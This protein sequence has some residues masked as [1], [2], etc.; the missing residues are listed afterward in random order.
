MYDVF[1]SYRRSDQALARDLVLALRGRGVR[2][3]WD[4]DIEGGEDWREAIVDNLTRS[5]TLV[6]LFSE[7]CNA[8]KQLKKEL[9]I[10]DSLDKDV[11][12]ILIEDT[13]PRGHYLYELATRNWL[14]AFPDPRS[15]VNSLADRLARELEQVPPEHGLAEEVAASRPPEPATPSPAPAQAVPPLTPGEL[16]SDP[17]LAERVAVKARRRARDRRDLLALKWYEMLI[18]LA[19]GALTAFGTLDQ[20]DDPALAAWDFLLG[21]VMSLM[22]IAVFVL[23]FRYYFRRRRV[24]RA[25][26]AYALSNLAL[27]FV[28]G[29]VIGIH[30][31]TYDPAAGGLE[32]LAYGITGSVVVVAVLS[33]VAFSIYGLLHFQRTVRSFRR[34]IEAV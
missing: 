30:P 23:P 25:V 21:T 6:I 1:L 27:A 10:A 31:D 4:Q 2:I 29:L 18:A 3:W 12:P 16:P 24:W 11:V 8:S 5:R 28:M 22:A 9:A 19:I 33:V 26:R 32:N 7:D 13:K 34:H 17:D 20:K 15:K 14:Q